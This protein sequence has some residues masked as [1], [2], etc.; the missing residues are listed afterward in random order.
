[1]ATGNYGVTLNVGHRN[2]QQWMTNFPVDR[3]M[4]ICASIRIHHHFGRY[5]NIV[6]I[7]VRKPG[8]WAEFCHSWI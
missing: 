6:W 5:W 7:Q 4:Q 3:L 1:V 8:Y 2:C